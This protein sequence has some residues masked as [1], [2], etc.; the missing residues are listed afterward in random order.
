ME[1]NG[2]WEYNFRVRS[3][4]VD[5]NNNMTLTSISEYLQEVAGD[6]ANTMGFGYRQVVLNQLAWILG[7]IRIEVNRLP[8]W[9]EDIKVK[10][11]VVEN[12]RFI[13]RRD[14]QWYDQEGNVL[15]NASTNWILINTERRRPVAID[16]MNFQV[17]L[18]PE[19]KATSAEIANIRAKFEDVNSID[20]QVRYS[21]LDMVGHMNNTKYIQLFFDQFS[22]N[23]HLKNTVKSL[24]IN[25]KNEA[26]YTN[27]LELNI[28][29][30][31]N[32]HIAILRRKEDEKVNCL[33]QIIWN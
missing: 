19:K 27:I 5:Q 16:S 28:Q 13:S 4:D 9:E 14:F 32:E 21:D 2:I 30:N 22:Q 3:F 12:N 24:D 31:S 15:L 1:N 17:K 10:T 6:H 8:L 11:W 29:K 7:G 33:A 25:F 23:F 26:K 18:H 20:Y